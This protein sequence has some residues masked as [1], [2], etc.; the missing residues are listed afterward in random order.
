MSIASNQTDLQE[1]AQ[2][3]DIRSKWDAHRRIRAAKQMQAAANE[4]QFHQA[5]NELGEICIRATG[6]DQLLAIALMVRISEFVKREFTASAAN[7]LGK[8]LSKRPE[9]FWTI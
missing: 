8:A 4:P 5:F 2:G 7:I 1:F 6:V 3:V 9:G